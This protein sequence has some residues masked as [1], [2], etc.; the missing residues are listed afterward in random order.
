MRNHVREAEHLIRLALVFLAGGAAFLLIRQAVVPPGFGVHGHYRAAALEEN[1]LRPAV[2]AGQAA[3]SDCHE[4]QVKQR[5]AG[6]HRGVACE[7]CHGP[8]ARHAADPS[9]AAPRPPDPVALC[10]RCHEADAAKPKNF[11]Q[12]V[13]Q[14]HSGGEACNSCHQPHRPKV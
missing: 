5:A 11:P 4:E 1:R 7:A 3:C 10:R 8:L 6:S 12:V 14:D 13:A 9:A 2:Y